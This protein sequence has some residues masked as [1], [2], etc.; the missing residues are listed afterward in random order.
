[1]SNRL[2]SLPL[3]RQR[4]LDLCP[5][6]S[7]SSERY[8]LYSLMTLQST[9]RYNSCA[10]ADVCI[11]TCEM[12]ALK[13]HIHRCIAWLEED[14]KGGIDRMKTSIS[15]V[16]IYFWLSTCT[17]WLMC[18]TRQKPL[19]HYRFWY[20]WKLRRDERSLVVL[21]RCLWLRV[22]VSSVWF[23]MTTH[24]AIHGL[25]WISFLFVLYFESFAPYLEPVHSF[26]RSISRWR[27]VVANESCH[28]HVKRNP[29]CNKKHVPRTKSTTSTCFF[30]DHN[31]CA[32]HVPISREIVEQILVRHIIWNMKNKQIASRRS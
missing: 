16:V 25:I 27:V 2:H 18:L 23:C 29:N 3:Y 9:P 14:P 12:Q 6:L 17:W 10:Q 22:E 7:D 30:F 28:V 8:V 4:N 19:F 11:C 31:A 20:T 21:A 32:D 26:D 5:T 15:Q 1:M 13:W 24:I